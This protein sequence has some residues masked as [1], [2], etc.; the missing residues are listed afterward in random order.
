ML[1]HFVDD[2]DEDGEAGESLVKVIPND[3]PYGIPAGSSHWVVWS[4]LP[5][6]H[7]SLFSTSDTPFDEDLR[8]QLYHCVT[9]DGI[10]GFTGFTPEHQPTHP[11]W[12]TGDQVVEILGS[13]SQSKLQEQHGGAKLTNQNIS[14]AH[15]WASRYVNKYIEKVWPTDRFV[16]AW[17]CNP[18][19]LRTVPG[20]SHFQ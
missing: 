1:R 3:W 9:G 18:P 5:I 8:E 13:Y 6:L 12:K 11:S 7:E 15:A 16:T 20:L 2:A 4:K 10:R 14:Q 19:S 17:F